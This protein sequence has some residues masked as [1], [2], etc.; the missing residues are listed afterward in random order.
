MHQEII[1]RSEAKFKMN[2]KL[3]TQKRPVEKKENIVGKGENVGKQY[4]FLLLQCFLH[5]K[6]KPNALRKI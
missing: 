3:T 5:M 2:L 4:F 6:N 1:V